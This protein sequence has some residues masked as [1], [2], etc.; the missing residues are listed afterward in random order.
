MKLNKDV[1]LRILS[2]NIFVIWALLAIALG[3]YIF[4]AAQNIDAPFIR[5]SEDTN[6]SNGIGALNWAKFGAANL[7][8]GLYPSWLD[9]AKDAQIGSFYANH[10][11]GFLFPTYLTY[12]LFGASETTTRL[13]PLALTVIA[14]AVFYFAVMRVFDSAPSA[15]FGILAFAALPGA[16]YYGKHLDMQPPALAMMLVTFS[17]FVFYY[18]TRKNAYF[19]ALLAS[20]FVGGLVAWFY[21][22]MPIG[23]LLFLLT[24]RAGN[25]PRRIHILALTPFLL[26]SAFVLNLYHFYILNGPS[27]AETLRGAFFNRTS[28]Q[29]FFFWLSSIWSRFEL[30]FTVYFVTL[31]L[32]GLFILLAEYRKH[33]NLALLFPLFAAPVLNLLVFRQWSTHPF[34]PI[35]FLPAA[36][37]AAAILFHKFMR[38]R[39]LEGAAIALIILAVGFYFSWQKLDFFYNKFLILGPKDVGMLKEIKPQ[40]GSEELCEGGNQF[41][42]GY[43]GI[44]QWYLEKKT[45]YAPTCFEKN[46]KIGLVFHPGIGKFYEDEANTFLS[47]AFR[48][49]D[50]ADALC[51]MRIQ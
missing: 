34:G 38:W 36:A 48:L 44:I 11:V 42:L 19:Y 21:Y 2:N 26:V 12:K 37:V 22:F 46:P 16:V 4:L 8:F 41:G 24:R 3:I 5:V 39:F 1:R 27:F 35:F 47:N 6:G 9:D 40:I 15:F 32:L 29:P 49:I 13:G 45:L 25:I 51:V 28:G 14:L 33:P 43:S 30:N 10:P 20:V 23:I 7:K 31:A 17:L 18:T 50:C